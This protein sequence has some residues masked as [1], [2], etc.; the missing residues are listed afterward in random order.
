[1]I[2]G[3]SSGWLI[4]IVCIVG[5]GFAASAL[6]V[7]GGCGADTLLID[8]GDPPKKDSKPEPPWGSRPLKP[9]D[10]DEF[11]TFANS[12]K[13]ILPYSCPRKYNDDGV[14]IA[15]GYE[16]YACKD[17][18]QWN[19]DV[20]AVGVAFPHITL[21]TNTKVAME[22][23]N[24]FIA[25]S[26]V[27]FKAAKVVPYLGNVI[28]LTDL[29]HEV[30]SKATEADGLCTCSRWHHARRQV[31]IEFPDISCRE[32]SYCQ[33]EDADECKMFEYH[34]TRDCKTTWVDYIDVNTNKPAKIKDGLK[35]T[36]LVIARTFGFWSRCGGDETIIPTNSSR[37]R[38]CCPE[39]HYAVI[40]SAHKG[41][42][43]ICVSDEYEANEQTLLRRACDQYCAA[44]IDGPMA[45]QCNH[46]DISDCSR[47]FSYADEDE[48]ETNLYDLEAGDEVNCN[49]RIIA[50]GREPSG[51]ETE[52]MSGPE[53]FEST[54]DH[55]ENCDPG[56]PIAATDTCS[57]LIKCSD[58]HDIA[59]ED[60]GST[61]LAT[62]FIAGYESVH[63][64]FGPEGASAG[65]L[66]FSA[67]GL[68]P[69]LTMDPSTGI[70][71]GIPTYQPPGNNTT[72]HTV[73]VDVLSTEPDYPYQ[74]ACSF[75]W[76]IQHPTEPRPSDPDG[77]VCGNG[78]PGIEASGVCCTQGCGI[79][80]GAGCGVRAGLPAGDCCVTDIIRAG[81]FCDEELQA[82]CIL[83]SPPDP[84][85][86]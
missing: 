58:Q 40:A 24:R 18:A 84:G 66:L 60:I 5:A 13:A 23:T 77:P 74:D 19:T 9:A 44:D 4:A 57:G 12:C 1:M 83:G 41:N 70:V 46:E 32:P 47:T 81:K 26:K 49:S 48:L 25:A 82:P 86:N 56:L 3:K 14:P 65:D 20:K 71:T 59:G 78:I 35:K 36:P 39:N 33:F 85:N 52:R 22:A 2:V 45:F 38:S 10:L 42:T 28:G 69:G 31:M 27:T 51:S 72:T 29:T 43:V 61:S 8:N 30:V 37:G 50:D 17:A 16:K 15:Y 64:P 7:P 11:P 68:P 54:F 21:D 63:G 75:T 79:C 62:Q 55:G 6:G 76:Y 73:Q 67:T 53:Y 80:G 34:S